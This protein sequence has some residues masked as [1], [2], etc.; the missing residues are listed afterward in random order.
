MDRSEE[1]VA[2]KTNLAMLVAQGIFAL[3]VGIVVTCVVLIV[4]THDPE[5]LA[6]HFERSEEGDHFLYVYEPQSSWYRSVPSWYNRVIIRFDEV[7]GKM[8]VLDCERT[9]YHYPLFFLSGLTVYTF[10][11]C[12][13]EAQ[14]DWFLGP[15]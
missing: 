2:K 11:D 5:P 9:K 3:V 4:T 6:P 15:S 14:S 12:T 10:E 7:D 13:N 1:T 8:V